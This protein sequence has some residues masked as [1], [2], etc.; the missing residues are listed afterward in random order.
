M[1]NKL[2]ILVGFAVAG[3]M[4]TSCFDD[5]VI[6]YDGPLQMEIKPG[7]VSAPNIQQGQPIVVSVQLIGPLQ[8]ETHTG[9]FNFVPDESFAVVSQNSATEDE[10]D[11]LYDIEYG[12]HFLLDG[13]DFTS[14]NTCEFEITPADSLVKDFV[15]TWNLDNIRTR[16]RNTVIFELQDEP[17]GASYQVAPN[18]VRS[19]VQGTRGNN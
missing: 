9:S 10:G 18:L 2:I 14:T 12:T 4:L 19:V 1:F 6:T 5:N 7:S 8:T 17:A 15:L 13:C 11:F 16:S 3:L